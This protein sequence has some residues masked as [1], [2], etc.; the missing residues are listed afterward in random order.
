M[1]SNPFPAFSK[2]QRHNVKYS[3]QLIDHEQAI[4]CYHAR[5]Y[6][7]RGRGARFGRDGGQQRGH[8]IE[9]HERRQQ[10]AYTDSLAHAAME[11]RFK[12]HKQQQSA[13]P[14]P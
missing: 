1:E 5:K 13:S 8:T 3:E 11:E 12:S 9:W 7:N 14:T 10:Q 4:L 6:K 2:L